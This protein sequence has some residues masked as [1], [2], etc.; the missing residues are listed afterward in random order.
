MNVSQVAHMAFRLPVLAFVAA[1]STIPNAGA[2][3][4]RHLKQ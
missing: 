4:W 2:F 1:Y 3:G